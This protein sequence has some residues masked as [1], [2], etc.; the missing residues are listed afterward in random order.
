MRMT[1]MTRRP[2]LLGEDQGKQNLL[3]VDM[4]CPK[5]ANKMEKQ[6]DKI[7]K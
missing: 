4:V 7:Q 3:I 1:Y 2:Q 5:K 6:A